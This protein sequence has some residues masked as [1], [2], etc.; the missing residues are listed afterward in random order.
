MGRL[1]PSPPYSLD[2]RWLAPG[3]SGSVR[4]DWSRLRVHHIATEDHPRFAEA[5]RRLWDEFGAAGGMEQEQVIRARLRWEGPMVY[6]MVLVETAEGGF[7]AVRDH[8]VIPVSVGGAVV[9][10]S[11]VLID[12][13]WRRTGLGGWMRAIPVLAARRCL[14]EGSGAM[15]LACEMEPSDGKDAARLIRLRAYEKA[16]FLKVD[17]AVIQYHQPDFRPPAVIDSSGGLRPL[18]MLLVLRRAGRESERSLT[19]R[20]LREIVG[21]LY[22]MY[23]ASFRPQDMAGVFQQLERYPADETEVRLLSPAV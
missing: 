23:A 14:G 1:N 20:E 15:T 4:F 17:P 2:P 21:S 13:A 3:D 22:R 9:H 8:T 11:H 6:E 16:G 18:P 12:P 7:A 19:G 10:M 5:Y